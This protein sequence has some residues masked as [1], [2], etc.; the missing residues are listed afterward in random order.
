MVLSV[1][2]PELAVHL[3]LQWEI[4][5]LS[6]FVQVLLPAA[7]LLALPPVGVVVFLPQFRVPAGEVYCRTS[8]KSCCHQ[9]FQHR[10][11]Y[12]TYLDSFN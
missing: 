6:A 3:Q 4:Q 9:Y 12:K 10:I 2:Q 11:W 7:G 1:L 5:E 8:G